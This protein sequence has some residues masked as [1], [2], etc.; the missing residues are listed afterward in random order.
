MV[1]FDRI[2]IFSKKL[3][4]A[5]KLV[6]FPRVLR[7]LSSVPRDQN[8]TGD[9]TFKALKMKF[10]NRKNAHYVKKRVKPNILSCLVTTNAFKNF[11]KYG[12]QSWYPLEAPEIAC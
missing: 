1:T 5:E 10:V 6:S 4:S 2:V 8:I 12:S 3:H 11:S 9:V 7:K